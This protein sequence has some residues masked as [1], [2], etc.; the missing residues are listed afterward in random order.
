[1]V[2]LLLSIAAMALCLI[3][4]RSESKPI[5]N[6]NASEIQIDSIVKFIT[7]DFEMDGRPSKAVINLKYKNFGNKKAF[8]LSLFITI[9]TVDK[10]SIGFPTNKEDT[11]FHQLEDEILAKLTPSGNYCY[12]GT[13]T[14]YGYRDILFF[15]KPKDKI[16]SEKILKTIQKKNSRIQSKTFHNDPEWE[17]VAEFYEAIK[18]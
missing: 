17:S 10:D 18:I 5:E 7:L 16:K 14:I 6:T 15:I 2:R 11:L 4:C 13:T 12:V 8:P 1:M 3:S 9:N